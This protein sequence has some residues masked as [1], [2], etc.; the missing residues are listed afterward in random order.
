[1]KKAIITGATGAI[2]MALIKLLSQKGVAVTAV[3]RPGSERNK[4]IPL[5]SGVT[6]V[7]CDISDYKK[8]PQLCGSGY[9]CFFHLA[10]SGTAGAARNDMYLQT[11]NIRAAVDSVYAA[12][13][14]GC[15]VYVGAGSQAEY[16]RVSGKLRSDT[17]V[18]PENG[19]G[20]AKLCAGNMTRV[21]CRGKN[22]RHI[23]TRILSVYGEYDGEGSMIS[24]AILAIL[25]GECPKF[26]AGEQRWDYLYSADAARALYLCAE[27]GRDGAVYPIGS[28]EERQL[29]EYITILRDSIDR[30]APIALGAVPYSP[31]QVMYLSA[32]IS[33]LTRDTGFLP[34]VSFGEGI[35]N[36]I[37][38]FKRKYPI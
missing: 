17:P 23:W 21:I 4:D 20:M 7:E 14:M 13:E 5:L 1:M 18:N 24:S 16:G 38:H 22:I 3:L 32:D 33:E 26:T 11:G 36:T 15:T 8:L 37:E 28:G 34:E 2:G 6:A 30:S 10:W 35:K 25:R 9:D 12:A 27:S 19:Y 29:C 31:Q